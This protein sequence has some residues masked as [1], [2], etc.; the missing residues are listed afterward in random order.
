MPSATIDGLSINYE[1]HGEQGNPLVLVHGA[2]GDI[3]DWRHQVAEFAST[4]RVLIMDLRGHGRSTA[5]TDR[6]AYS[7]DRMARDVV[8]LVDQA[9]FDRYHLV[10]HSMGGAISQEVALAD[11]SR[12]I[13]LTLFDTGYAHPRVPDERLARYNAKRHRIAEEQGMAAARQHAVALRASRRS[14]PKSAARKNAPA[15]RACQSTPS[16]ASPAAPPPGPAPAAASKPSPSPP[17]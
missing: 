8:E 16:S 10:G 12:M 14:R 5:P 17:S 11:P 6:D 4:H 1:L 3:T 2:T 15:S 9:G 13:T 7:I